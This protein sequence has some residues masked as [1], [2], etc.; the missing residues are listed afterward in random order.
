M[1]LYCVRHGEAESPEVNP[2][3]PLTANGQA[4]IQKLAA[5]LAGFPLKI[6]QLLHSDKLRAVQTAEILAQE[7]CIPKIISSP[8]ILSEDSTIRSMEEMLIVEQDN[9][10]LV[11]HLPF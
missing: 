4:E 8:K 3:R 1:K 9:T 11:G 5:Y 7:L 10:M 2:K 6:Q